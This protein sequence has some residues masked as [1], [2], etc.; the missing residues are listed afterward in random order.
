MVL[1]IWERVGDI[2]I[3]FTCIV[4]DSIVSKWPLA[5]LSLGLCINLEPTVRRMSKRENTTRCSPSLQLVDF[6]VH[7]ERCSRAEPEL[8]RR[9]GQMIKYV[10]QCSE[11]ELKELISAV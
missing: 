11:A 7:A 4:L 10:V 9:S 5:L 1:T 8:D 2:W 6:S 3:Y